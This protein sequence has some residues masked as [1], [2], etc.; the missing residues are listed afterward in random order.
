M[1]IAGIFKSAC[2]LS[3][4]GTGLAA[5]LWWFKA[6]RKLDLPLAELVDYFSSAKFTTFLQMIVTFEAL[7]HSSQKHKKK[8][9]LSDSRK[10]AC[11]YS[12]V[13]TT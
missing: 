2:I 6:S 13:Q 7:T 10:D 9:L 4:A 11:W 1:E 5:F 8:K 3:L 12:P